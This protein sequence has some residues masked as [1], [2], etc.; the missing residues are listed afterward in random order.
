MYKYKIV[1]K[2]DEEKALILSNI[3]KINNFVY[4]DDNLEDV[5]RKITFVNYSD[6]DK[7]IINDFER[8][9]TVDFKDGLY[10]MCYDLDTIGKKESTIKT[11][12]D[13]IIFCKS[14]NDDKNFCE[15]FYYSFGLRLLDSF[16]DKEHERDMLDEISD[17][18]LV[19]FSNELDVNKNNVLMHS[20]LHDR[21]LLPFIYDS[22]MGTGSF[23]DLNE[24]G[25]KLVLDFSL[26]NRNISDYEFNY[27]MSSLKD[28]FYKRIESIDLYSVK[29]E[30][31]IKRFEEEYSK[32]IK[33]QKEYK[34]SRH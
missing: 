4:H 11:I 9:T 15:L 12:M 2:T 29:K 27:I 26:N 1:C 31:M 33:R 24:I 5:Y 23:K 25:D 14:G 3:L 21:T 18:G 10:F 28:F 7:K 13:L 34:K 20:F 6:I 22:V 8:S 32:L 17:F 19:V 16:L 30:A